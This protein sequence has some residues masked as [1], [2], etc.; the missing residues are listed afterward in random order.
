[1]TRK[2]KKTASKKPAVV[3]NY[4]PKRRTHRR[5]ATKI[6]VL[7]RRSKIRKKTNL[8]S[9]ATEALVITGTALAGAF[10]FNKIPKVSPKLLGAGSLVA[11]SVIGM[12][13]QKPML[14]NVS[15]GLAV[16]GAMTLVRQ[17]VPQTQIVMGE[18]PNLL[19]YS[20]E[21]LIRYNGEE[22]GE[23][24]TAGEFSTAGEEYGEESGEDLTGEFETSGSSWKM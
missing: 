7:P 9:F 8:M 17:F 6:A 4:T 19:G 15:I 20:D 10:I 12:K 21:Q 13:T 3:R 22:S 14:K 16:L 23:F 11:G 2:K 5:A 24:N 18:D 1:M